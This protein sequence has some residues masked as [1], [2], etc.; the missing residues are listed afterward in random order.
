MTLPYE[1]TFD[2]CIPLD[3]DHFTY[4]N[5]T[6]PKLPPKEEERGVGGE[7]DGEVGDFYYGV[8]NPDSF[9][10]IQEEVIIPP[11][12]DINEFNTRYQQRQLSTSN[13]S[14]ITANNSSTS[15][16]KYNS[17]MSRNNSINMKSTGGVGVG[18]GVGNGVGSI[19][20]SRSLSMASTC[21]TAN[22]PPSTPLSLTHFKT[23]SFDVYGR[24]VQDEEQDG[25]DDLAI[26]ILNVI[27]QNE[28][29]W[30]I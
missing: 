3:Y 8:N 19:N 20:M 23:S 12:P 16:N 5:I 22:L 24:G 6:S 26:N 25:D 10:S 1:S 9:N 21:T 18:V 4:T 28:I 2:T 11:L 13:N 15:L 29:T 27:N 14:I 30:D 17:G 7:D